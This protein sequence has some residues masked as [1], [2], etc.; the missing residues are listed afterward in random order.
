MM[1]LSALAEGRFFFAACQQPNQYHYSFP[2]PARS[3]DFFASSV[4]T[5][6]GSDWH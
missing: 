5:E 2:V 3:F 4:S 6:P 1:G